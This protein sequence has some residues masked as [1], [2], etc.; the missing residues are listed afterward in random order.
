VLGLF[1]VLAWCLQRVGPKN[2]AR[3]PKE[4][5]DVVG[6]APLV[7]RQQMQLVRVGNRLLLLAIQSGSAET[8]VE[9]SE[10][11][12]V[13]HLLA[14]CRRGAAG[15]ASATFRQAL[16]EMAGGREDAPRGRTAAVAGMRGGR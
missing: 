9:I 10:P 6:E 2:S 3:L 8:L 13:E 12:E 1:F 14:L 7:G 15:S 4:A 11:A 16:E 5:V